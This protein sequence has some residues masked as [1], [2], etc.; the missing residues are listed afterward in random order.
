M[1]PLAGFD[2][3]N[4]LATQ[5]IT[6]AIGILALS[7]TFIKDVLNKKGQVVT[8]PLKTAWFAYLSSVV[9]GMWDMMAITGSTFRAI[10]N[11][12]EPI[13]YGANIAVPAL[14]QIVAFLVATSFLIWYGAKTLRFRATQPAPAST[15]G[16]DLTIHERQRS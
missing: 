5:L 10:A 13:T 9:F 4:E 7:I 16:A 2:S 8:W 15:E 14:L 6:L 12:T 11:P 1:N 3:A